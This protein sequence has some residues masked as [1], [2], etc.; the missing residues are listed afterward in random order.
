MTST[1]KR[2]STIQ[3]RSVI[4]NSRD[5]KK[6]QQ[7]IY[8]ST[9]QCEHSIYIQYIF[10]VVDLVVEWQ[11]VCCCCKGLYSFL[12]FLFSHKL[13]IRFRNA[14]GVVRQY[15]VLLPEQEKSEDVVVV[16]AASTGFAWLNI[17]GS[18]H[19]RRLELMDAWLR[20]RPL[21]DIIHNFGGYCML[22]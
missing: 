12:F 18:Q 8:S 6:Q 3:Q 5:C 20:P 2:N 11:Q 21:L 16:V 19:S 1:S 17:C 22:L 9:Q 4:S 10:G 13:S 7:Y 14:N 15:N